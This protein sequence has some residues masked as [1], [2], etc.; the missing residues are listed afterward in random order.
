MMEYRF[1]PLLLTTALL[2]TAVEAQQAA[3]PIAPYIAREINA[4]EHDA[5]NRSVLLISQG[6][7]TQASAL[8]KP[9]LLPPVIPVYVDWTPV[10]RARRAACRQMAQEAIQTW[11]RDLGGRSKFALTESE[12]NANLRLL[13]DR[14]IARV[15]DGQATLICADLRFDPGVLAGTAKRRTAE[16]RIALDVPYLDQPHSAASMTHLFGQVLGLYLGLA[17]S[18]NAADL[19]GPDTH[20]ATVARTASKQDI[21]RIREL[22]QARRTLARYAQQ[23]VAAYV[24]KA[25][26]ALDKEEI[27]AGEVQRGDKARYVFKIRNTGDA[28]LEITA[29]PNCG[30]TVANYD[31]VIAPGREGKIEADINT[32]S[33]RGPI[34]KLIELTTNDPNRPKTSL[35][36]VATVQSAI[37]VLPGEV[38]TVPLRDTAPT[39]RELEVRT[40]EKQ[41]VEVTQVTCA[42]PYAT[43]KLDPL[44]AP[45]GKGRAY[46]VTLTIQTEAPLGRSAFLVTA[47]TTSSREPQVN[48]T[49]ICDKG[50]VA[51]PPSLYMGNITPSAALPLT[52][53]F[54]LSR[55]DGVFHIRK[56][57]CDDPKLQ[58]K[59]ETLQEGRQYRVTVTYN[60]G[61][62]AGNIRSKIVVETDDPRQSQFEIPVMA[63]VAGSASR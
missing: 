46:K 21:A 12:E 11:N 9:L 15:Q 26:L 34:Q 25:V 30:C 32:A 24:P 47:S 17:P 41:P 62:A 59:Q 22:E 61:W 31:K 35:R 20:A 58:I 51:M 7:F 44:P 43:A 37:T 3:K 40:S 38:I 6:Q 52:T 55:A 29:K 16:A 56:V 48:I 42:V 63:N 23:R 5:L 14:N 45:D 53:L 50:I 2:P 10:P 18:E 28:P 13:F 1:L 33:F 39:V 27:D 57:A 54:T 8:L 49:A 36:L 60:G 19:M 4:P